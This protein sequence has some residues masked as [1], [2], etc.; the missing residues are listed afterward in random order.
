MKK[1]FG[2]IEQYFFSAFFFSFFS[3]NHLY[4]AGPV[5]PEHSF[6]YILKKKKMVRSKNKIV[7]KIDINKSQM[8][9]GREMRVLWGFRAGYWYTKSTKTITLIFFCFHNPF[10]KP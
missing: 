3:F 8:T 6:Y 10:L 9:G 5:F 1:S 7:R 2:L 4:R